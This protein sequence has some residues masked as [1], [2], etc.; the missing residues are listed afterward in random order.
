MLCH[1][2]YLIYLS[3]FFSSL[4][5][6]CRSF[7]ITHVPTYEH[8]SASSWKKL[9]MCRSLSSTSYGSMKNKEG[10]SSL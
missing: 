9:L 3:L 7:Q 8:V 5:P 10:V 1:D 2:Y 4:F 6:S